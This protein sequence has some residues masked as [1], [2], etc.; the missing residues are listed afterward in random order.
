MK[1]IGA[2]VSVAGGVENAPLNANKIGAKAFAMFTKNQRRWESKPLTE[3]SII[4]FKENLKEYGYKPEQILPHDGYLI[5]LGNPDD[6]KREK[7]YNS[8]L[9]ELKRCEQ[10]GL[11]YL[12]I[13]PGSHL[14]LISEEECLDRI[15]ESINRALEETTSVTVVLENTAGQGTNLGYKFEHLAYI[16]DKIKDKSRIGVCYDTCHGFAAGYDIRTKEKYEET[17]E[18]FDKIIGL[19]YLKAFHVNDAKS[20]FKS[21]V[22]RHH[23][24]GQGNIGVDAFKFLMADPRFEEKPMILETKDETL[25]PEE[26]KMLYKFAGE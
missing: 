9:D 21:K 26:I 19:K 4:K 12:N 2:H 20:E 5:N 8:F 11:V 25:W 18:E 6:E 22:D 10:L 16:I 14:K 15:S 1:W 13:H 17:F 23:N 7:S 3:K 24:I